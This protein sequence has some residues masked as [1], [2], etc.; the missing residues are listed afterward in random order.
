M[1]KSTLNLYRESYAGLRKE[2]W[3]L[4]LVLLINR[5]GAMV[6]PFLTIY[7]TVQY[8]FSLI[9]AGLIVS[10]FGFGSVAGSYVGGWIT[11]RWGFYR[12]Q[13]WTLIIGGFLFWVVGLQ[14]TFWE[15]WISIFIL[16]VVLNGFRPANQTALAYYSNPE[17]RTRAFGLLRM[18]VNLGYSMGPFFGGILIVSLGYKWLFIINGLSCLLAALTF[19]LLLPRGRQ[20]EKKKEKPTTKNSV[21]A[22]ANIPF[23]TFVFFLMIGAVCFMQMFSSLP[24]YLKEHLSY[25]EQDIGLLMVLNGLLIAIVEMPL[26]HKLGQR[27]NSLPLI[28]VGFILMGLSFYFLNIAGWASVF[29][30]IYMILLTFGEMLSMPFAST[31][32]AAIAPEERRGEYMGLLGI[33]WAVAFIIAPTLSLWWAENYGFFSLFWFSLGLGMVS[34]LGIYVIYKRV[35]KY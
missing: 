13:L 15:F 31:Y 33:G 22:Y 18:T 3:Y 4:S 21:S 17:N 23:M 27:F 7:L 35:A 29:V 24:I 6:L 20:E 12:V 9:D 10:S 25:T 2:V 26:I 5:M 11:D 34:G 14:E 16:S 8:N 1:L 30:I 19:L 28:A 32:T